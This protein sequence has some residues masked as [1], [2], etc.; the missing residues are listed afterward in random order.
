M[1]IAGLWDAIGLFANEELAGTVEDRFN[2]VDFD[3][4]AILFFSPFCS[5][6]L[7]AIVLGAYQAGNLSAAS[8]AEMADVEQM[9]QV[10]PFV[11]CEIYLWPKCLRVDVWYQCIGSEF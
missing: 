7:F 8:R 11:T 10:V 3:F 4:A 6:I 5:C 2:A 9:K 1:S